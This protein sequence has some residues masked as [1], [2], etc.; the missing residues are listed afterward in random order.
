M[1]SRSQKVVSIWLL[2]GCVMVFFQVILGGITRL[3]ESGLSITEW[4]P[5]KGTIPPLN[6]T[7]WNAE[8]ELYKQKVQYQTINEGMTLEE[9][10]W[11]F[12]WEY[13]HRLWARLLMVVFLIPFIYF[14]YKKYI[15]RNLAMHLGGL[16][17]FGALQGFVG[18][19]M[20]RAGLTGMFVP[21]L[22]LTVHL[23]LALGLYAYLVGLTLKVYRGSGNYSSASSGLKLL[24]LTILGVLVIQLFLGGILSGMKAGLSFPTWPDM[25]GHFIPSVLSTERPTLQGLLAYN[26]QDIWGRAFIQFFHRATAYLLV[27]LVVVFYFRSRNITSDKFFKTGLNLFPYIIVLQALLGI[28]TVINCVGKVPVFWGALHQAGAMLLLG[29]TIFIIFHLY[30]AQPKTE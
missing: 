15:T 19:I 2:T 8:F 18:W 3:T 27:V 23:V 10:K 16:F 20:V 9:F 14:L 7:E 28:I 6:A 13:F 24:A 22:R 1:P 25:N 26:P 12:F 21:P 30:S 4:K 5:I 17:V 29:E 11:I